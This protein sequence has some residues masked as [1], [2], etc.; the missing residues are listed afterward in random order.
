MHLRSDEHPSRASTTI[1]DVARVAG[2]SVATVSRVLNDP[3]VVTFETRERVVAAISHLRYSPNPAAASLRR[4]RRPEQT[5]ASWTLDDSD[6]QKRNDSR[7]NQDPAG[8]RQLQILRREN[9]ELKR[10]I[11]DLGI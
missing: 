5:S 2:V 3:A 10:I 1:R 6:I 11:R 9:S 4:T 7:T 8:A